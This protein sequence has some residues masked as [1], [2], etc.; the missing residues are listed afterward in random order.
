M[1]PVDET[2]FNAHLFQ[3]AKYLRPVD[4]IISFHKV[5]KSHVW[6]LTTMSDKVL[7]VAEV[8][9]MVMHRPSSH[10]C[11]FILMDQFDKTC[12]KSIRHHF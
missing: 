10:G 8:S 11:F 4:V 7:D 9:N 12:G 5:E 1:N 3:N 6:F 2:F